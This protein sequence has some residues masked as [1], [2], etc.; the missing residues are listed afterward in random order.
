[1]KGPSESHFS[2]GLFAAWQGDGR[3][4]IILVDD[5]GEIFNN[6]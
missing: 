2:D 1:M 5:M 6:G 4:E 3:G